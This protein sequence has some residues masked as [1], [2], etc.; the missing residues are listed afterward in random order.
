MKDHTTTPTAELLAEWGKQ[1]QLN[2]YIYRT[3]ADEDFANMDLI[4]AIAAELDSRAS[5]MEISIDP[6][7]GWCYCERY[8]YNPEEL[9]DLLTW[10]IQKG[11]NG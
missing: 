6:D 7:D 11:G 5:D 4:A 10:L 1:Q 8:R 3:T 9:R 2:D